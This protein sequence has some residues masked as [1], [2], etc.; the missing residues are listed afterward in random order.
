MQLW[1]T[2]TKEEGPCAA[3]GGPRE[4]FSLRPVQWGSNMAI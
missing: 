2:P 1:L 3:L 4:S